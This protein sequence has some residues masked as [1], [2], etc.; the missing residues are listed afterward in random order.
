LPGI[1][2]PM[3]GCGDFDVR[4]GAANASQK[5]KINAE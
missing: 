1:S 3:S 5:I 4:G 2:D